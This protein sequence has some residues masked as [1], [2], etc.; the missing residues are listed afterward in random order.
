MG[1]EKEK[2]LG[3]YS[4]EGKDYS[5]GCQ[6]AAANNAGDNSDSKSCSGEDQENPTEAAEG[7]D[8]REEVS[9]DSTL[10]PNETVCSEEWRKIK[11]E[12]ELLEE[13]LRL[14]ESQM[15][16]MISR[17]QRLQADFENFRKRTQKEKEEMRDTAAAALV[18]ALLPVFDNF[19]R[20][21]N[22]PASDDLSFREGVKMI[23]KQ[24]QQV[25]A[26]AGLEPIECVGTIFDP[27]FQQAVFRAEDDSLEENTVIE[28]LQKGFMFG[29]KV[30]RPAMVKVSCKSAPAE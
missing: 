11:E 6:E 15:E 17:F 2:G 14:K 20:A 21:V 10:I 13:Q 23:F 12:R 25:L 24:F 1:R 3:R 7:R 30:L 22:A 19:D 27:N 26:D 9:E 28:E 8:S 4:D 5:S 16:E 29:G 18:E